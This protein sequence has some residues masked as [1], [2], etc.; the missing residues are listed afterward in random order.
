[1]KIVYHDSVNCQIMKVALVHDYL[2]EYGGAERVLESMPQ[3]CTYFAPEA[4]SLALAKSV[5]TGLRFLIII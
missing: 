5:S 2:R 1:M 3:Y 4:Y